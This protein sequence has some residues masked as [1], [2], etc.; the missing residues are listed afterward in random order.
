M[1]RNK[2]KRTPF[3]ANTLRMD[4]DDDTKRRL[5]KDG[6]VPVWVNDTA[7]NIARHQA[8]DYDFVYANEVGS[9]EQERT[10]ATTMRVGTTKHGEAINAYLMAIPQEYYNEDQELKEERNRKVDRAIKGGE[11]SGS[12]G[13]DPSVGSTSVKKVSYEP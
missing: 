7:D 10:N 12:L 6:L 8:G 5:K 1:R 11:S 2:R 4:I 3:Q 13:V 9:E